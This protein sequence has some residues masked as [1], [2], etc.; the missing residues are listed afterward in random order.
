M[1]QLGEEFEETTVDGRV[2]TGLV[3]L[4]EGKIISR[5]TAKKAG[6][7]STKST[8][9]FFDDKCVYTIEIF[10][11]DIICTQTFTRQTEK[12]FS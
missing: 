7:K 1:L 11:S 3:V 8:R 12:I 2:V 5:Q 4:E 9:E 10:D 6:E